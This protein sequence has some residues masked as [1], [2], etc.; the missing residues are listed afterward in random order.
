[1][2]N[3][4]QG[5]SSL[6]QISRTPT[7]FFPPLRSGKTGHVQGF[8]IVDLQGLSWWI[9]EIFQRNIECKLHRGQFR[10]F[11]EDVTM[12]WDR[13]FVSSVKMGIWV[14]G[15][16]RDLR[17]W[18]LGILM[19]PWSVVLAGNT[20]NVHSTCWRPP[21]ISQGLGWVKWVGSK[22]DRSFSFYSFLVEIENRYFSI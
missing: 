21:H 8:V 20:C 6:T 14:G 18:T 7:S 10:G 15:P 22:E 9:L 13:I 4:M 1:M 2:W 11:P 3:A 19:G 17:S 12:P 5:L 16:A